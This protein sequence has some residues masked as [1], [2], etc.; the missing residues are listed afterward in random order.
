MEE[1]AWKSQ[2]RLGFVHVRLELY[3]SCPPSDAYAPT[4]MLGTSWVYFWHHWKQSCKGMGV[5]GPM[6]STCVCFWRTW[7]T[8]G[9]PMKCMCSTSQS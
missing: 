9:E 2:G 1:K 5:H 7:G 8:L 6:L 4:Q 3:V